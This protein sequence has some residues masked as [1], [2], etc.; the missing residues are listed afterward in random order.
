V[1]VDP[2]SRVTRVSAGNPEFAAGRSVQLRAISGHRD[3]YPTS[4]PGANVYAQLPSIARQVAETGVPKIYSPVVFGGLGGSVRFTAKLSGAVPWTVEVEDALGHVVGSGSGTSRTVDWTW[5]A[6]TEP[7][8]TYTYAISASSNGSQARPVVGTIGQA[9]P[10]LSVTQLRVQPGVVSPNGDGSNDKAQIAYVLGATAK[11]VVSLTDAAGNSLATL[12]G[13][14]MTAGAHAF[15]WRDIT[16][17]DGLYRI[18]ISATAAN[19]KTVSGTT[20]FYV[21]RTLAQ[22]TTAPLAISPN[23]DGRFDQTTLGF[24]LATAAAVRVELWRSGRLLATLL[25]QMLGPGPASLVWN[26][27]LGARAARDGRYDLVT[28]ATDSVTTVTEKSTVTVDTTP[29]RLRLASLARM[30]FWI[31]EPA[32]FSARF[33]A[34]TVS[35][36]VRRGYFSFPAFR[37][38]KHF[39]VRAADPLGNASRVLRR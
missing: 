13:G 5:D 29:P 28:K 14:T 6:S 39:T 25:N 24:R 37:R 20:S 4:C 7:R 32:T 27:R 19:G 38:A 30:Q 3:A 31:S 22:L 23:G 15:T 34:R 8:G 17:A 18:T 33:G 36:N 2:S 12:Y 35:R 11:V 16:I 10:Q 26:G 21:D 1:H 9:I